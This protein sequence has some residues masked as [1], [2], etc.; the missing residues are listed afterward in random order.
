MTAKLRILGPNLATQPCDR[1]SCT[2]KDQGF[3][4]DASCRLKVPVCIARLLLE[5]IKLG[6]TSYIGWTMAESMHVHLSLWKRHHIF[7]SLLA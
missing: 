5:E 4:L 1:S 3:D 7:P 2:Y 6:R